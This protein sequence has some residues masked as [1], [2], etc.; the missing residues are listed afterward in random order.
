MYKWYNV[1]NVE[2]WNILDVYLIKNTIISFSI[3]L[4][5]PFGLCLLPGIF[6]IQALKTKNKDKTFLYNMSKILQLI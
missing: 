6:R 3:G 2:F 5:Y 4:L 1:L